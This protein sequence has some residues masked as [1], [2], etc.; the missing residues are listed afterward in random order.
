YL[1]RHPGSADGTFNYAYHL[2]RDG[3]FESAITR[4]TQALKFGI[5]QPEEVHLNIANIYMDHLH[6][7][8]KAKAHLNDALTLNPRYANAWFNLGNLAEQCGQR[9]EGKSS[10]EKCL[11]FDPLNHTALARLAD[12][13][14]FNSPS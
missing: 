8:K 14:R 11:Q 9:D 7:N 12:A 5:T 2:P 4:Y 10:F 1:A 13:H 6:D 3:Q